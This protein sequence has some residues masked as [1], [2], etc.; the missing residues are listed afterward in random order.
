MQVWEKYVE[1]VIADG[2]DAADGATNGHAGGSSR[3]RLDVVVTEVV[4]GGSF[5]AQKAEEPRVAWLQEQLR[6]VPSGAAGSKARCTRLT[7]RLM[8]RVEGRTAP[9]E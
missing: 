4:D 9:C 1:P 6:L 3:E 7:S 5:W 2:D 8:W